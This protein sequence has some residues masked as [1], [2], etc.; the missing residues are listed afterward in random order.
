MNRTQ[1]IEGLATRVAQ[2]A[3]PG[4]LLFWNPDETTL[5]WAQL[6]LPPERWTALAAEDSGAAVHLE[7]TLRS[8]PPTTIVSLIAG[9][10]WSRREWLEYLQG[11]ATAAALAAPMQSAEPTLSVAALVKI[12]QLERPGGRG[13]WLWRL[14][15]PATPCPPDGNASWRAK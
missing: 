11:H 9:P 5:A 1:D 2:A 10:G 6:Y 12:A 4:P 8:A 13:Y 7:Q 15:E 3:G 14:C